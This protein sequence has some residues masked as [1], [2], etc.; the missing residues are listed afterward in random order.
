MNF[1]KK[2]ESFFSPLFEGRT[3]IK[4]SEWNKLKSRLSD[5]WIFRTKIW[6]IYEIRGRR[7]EFSMESM[8]ITKKEDESFELKIKRA[9]GYYDDLP[10]FGEKGWEEKWNEKEWNFEYKFENIE[11]L[12]KFLLEY[13]WQN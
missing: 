2:Y 12:I 7:T 13:K 10:T 6:D 1:I 9:P 5:F 8:E 3:D 11:D 4:T